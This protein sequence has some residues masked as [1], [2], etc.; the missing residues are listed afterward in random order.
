MRQRIDELSR[1]QNFPRSRLP[2]FTAEEVKSLKGTV[3][4]IG[5]N[6]YSAYLVSEGHSKV[7]KTPSFQNDMNVSL[8]QDP[9]WPRSNS[10]WLRVSS[11]TANLH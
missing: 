9:T 8:R 3:D 10:S 1:K 5:L 4:I 11:M 6:T 2:V 7:D